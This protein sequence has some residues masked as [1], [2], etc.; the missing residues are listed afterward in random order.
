MELFLT[1]HEFKISEIQHVVQY[2]ESE[3]KYRFQIPQICPMVK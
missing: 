2:L 1:K 3:A